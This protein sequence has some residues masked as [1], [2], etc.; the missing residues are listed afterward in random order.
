MAWQRLLLP[1]CGP[2]VCAPCSM[3]VFLSRVYRFRP[4]IMHHSW[5][6]GCKSAL[7]VARN[8][9]H[10]SR[11]PLLGFSINMMIAKAP[12]V[13]PKATPA[14]VMAASQNAHSRSITS[15]AVMS[16]RTSALSDARRDSFGSGFMATDGWLAAQIS[17]TFHLAGKT[18]V[19]CRV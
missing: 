19:S 8:R 18:D 1:L 3:L 2:Q 12:K 11:R 7:A 4:R 6:S 14:T 9:P 15:H 16:A 17:F 10:I 5:E 13:R